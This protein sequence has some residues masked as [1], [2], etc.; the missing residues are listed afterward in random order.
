MQDEIQNQQ[1]ESGEPD[2]PATADSAL[3]RLT[4]S[5]VDPEKLKALKEKLAKLSS[6]TD[7]THSGSEA[8]PEAAP[9]FDPNLPRLLTGG[10]VEWREY[11]LDFNVAHLYPKAAQR[12]TPEG[13]KWIAM[14]V[15]FTSSIKN[16]DKWGEVCNAPGSVDKLVTEPKNLAEWLGDMVNG[17]EQ[18]RI[19]AVMPGPNGQCGVLLEREVPV[20]LPDP[21]PL[22]KKEEVEAPG[23]PE[24]RAVEDAALNFMAEQKDVDTALPVEDTTSGTGL[25]P[26]LKG[27]EEEASIKA[28][29]EDG[30]IAPREDARRTVK[31]ALELNRPYDVAAPQG[32]GIQPPPFENPV[33]GGAL[34]VAEGARA[35]QDLL[36]ALTDPEFR[37]SLPKED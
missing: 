5:G 36:R 34:N 9:Q 12:V 8:V 24:L 11:N 37:A 21:L 35:A 16:F 2:Q 15:Q 18:W 7:K 6:S 13:I 32:K 20:V 3:A 29:L 25:R 23:D 28:S 1:N 4:A 17:R 22:Q 10:D 33:I 26:I 31:V 27:S 30:A 14:V 19:A